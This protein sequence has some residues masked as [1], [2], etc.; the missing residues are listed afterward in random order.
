MLLLRNA[1]RELPDLTDYDS[2]MHS[3]HGIYWQRK[4]NHSFV[5]NILAQALYELFAAQDSEFFISFAM[6][7]TIILYSIQVQG[8]WLTIHVLELI[9]CTGGRVI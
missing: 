4:T 1:L 7:E 6:N 3:T 9:T 5:V 8:V 2:V